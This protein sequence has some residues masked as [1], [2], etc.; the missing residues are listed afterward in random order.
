MLSKTFPENTAKTKK[1]LSKDRT[2]SGMKNT[3]KT[4]KVLSK[5]RTKTGMRSTGQK[6]KNSKRRNEFKENHEE[7]DPSLEA[8]PRKRQ[9][10]NSY[11]RNK[12]SKRY[13]VTS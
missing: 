13:S 12:G 6:A 8:P 5:D 11:A 10:L 9:K 3:A 2:N 7:L 1:V 4:K